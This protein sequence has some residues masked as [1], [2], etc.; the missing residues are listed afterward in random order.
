VHVS[1]FEGLFRPQGRIN[2]ENNKSGTR[3]L[4]EEENNVKRRGREE[5]TKKLYRRIWNR[6]SMIIRWK[7]GRS[8]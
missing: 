8:K 6:R 4:K 2:C 5:R 7:R 3:N 1:K